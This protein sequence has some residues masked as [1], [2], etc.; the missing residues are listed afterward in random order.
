LKG[1]IK[2]GAPPQFYSFT[3]GPGEVVF[4][5]DVA[6]AEPGGGAAYIYLIKPDAP[7]DFLDGFDLF[8]PAGS[9]GNLVKSVQFA[10]RQTIILRV[11]GHIGGG[12]Y[13]LRISGAATL[14]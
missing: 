3:A 9:S 2:E 13:R 6:G 10:E 4:T 7:D 11:G 12:T 1:D 5:L 14:N 8:A